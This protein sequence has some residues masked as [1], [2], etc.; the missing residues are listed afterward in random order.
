MA[1][2]VIIYSILDKKAFNED[3]NFF[4]ECLLTKRETESK[5]NKLNDLSEED[6]T[7]NHLAILQE[8]KEQYA[9][10]LS[11][12]PTVEEISYLPSEV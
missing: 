4:K 1:S 7:D 5:Y 6:Q 9:L 3:R 8:A 11:L 2:D 12:E 10:A